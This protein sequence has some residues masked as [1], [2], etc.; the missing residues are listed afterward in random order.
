MKKGEMIM[1]CGEIN[2]L[3][4]HSLSTNIPASNPIMIQ[5]HIHYNLYQQKTHTV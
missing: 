4:L 5:G 2:S 3:Q 1:C